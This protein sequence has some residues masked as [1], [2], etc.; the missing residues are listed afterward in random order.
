MQKSERSILLEIKKASNLLKGE[1]S[2]KVIRGQIKLLRKYKH[3][4]QARAELVIEHFQNHHDLNPEIVFSWALEAANRGDAR[5]MVNAGYCYANGI[6]VKK[7][8]K[9]AIKWLLKA[10]KAEM[11]EAFYNLA[12]H[13]EAGEGVV[14]NRKQAF[15]YYKLAA[16]KG[17]EPEFN[18]ALGWCYENGFGV[19][20]DL[21]NAVKYYRKAAKEGDESALS[22]LGLSY[23]YGRGVKSSTSKAI[24]FFSKAAQKGHSRS[25]EMLGLIYIGEEGALKKID[26]A[27]GKKFLKLA[28]KLNAF[29]AQL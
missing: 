20:L 13:F 29:E 4:A 6:G 5:N 22:N 1:A 28:A 16:N 19:R 14:K 27:K 24:E 25:C 2:A 26:L 3:I 11:P 17:S 9:S 7:D 12:K 18:L 10:S 21:K 8:Y 23:L 15:H